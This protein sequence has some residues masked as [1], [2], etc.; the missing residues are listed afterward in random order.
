DVDCHGTF[1]YR[2]FRS[3]RT[4]VVGRAPKR[5]QLAEEAWQT[6]GQRLLNTNPAAPS[7]VIG[8]NGKS[9]GELAWGQPT[10]ADQ[11][12]DTEIN[13]P[14]V[15]ANATS[16]SPPHGPDSAKIIRP[17]IAKVRYRSSGRPED[18]KARLIALWHQSLKRREK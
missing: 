13:D 3:N 7:N 11:E 8:L 6:A 4:G 15:Q 1:G 16:R 14:D 2:N 10:C 9:P 17:K 5:D 12:F 18:V